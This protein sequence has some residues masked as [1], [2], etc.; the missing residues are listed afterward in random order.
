MISLD[1]IK[2]F[3]PANLHGREEFLLREYLQYKIL[4][5]IFQ[6]NYAQQFS[7]LGGTCL[8]IV[9]NNQRFSEDLDFDNFDLSEEDF[10]SVSEMIKS[11]LEA[12]GYTVQIRNVL[13]GAF[14]CYIRFPGLLHQ[15]GLSGHR[16]AKILINIVTEPQ[17]FTY[18]PD[19]HY[20]NKFDVFTSLFCT[21]P[22]ILLSQ[23]LYA[24]T[25]RRQPKGR[26]FFDAIFLMGW[27]KPNYQYLDY[28]LG[29]SSPIDLRKIILDKIQPFDFKFLAN[30]V[31]PFLFNPN[32]AMRVEQF[33]HYFKQAKL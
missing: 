6:S 29:V 11:G 13:R 24:I 17:G 4:E 32:D 3:Y 9:H 7:F 5:L 31:K 19:I 30:D 22:D 2:K 12:E 25:N 26:D 18:K 16:E 1:E 8:R 33:P 27:T 10:T 14:H 23:K 20:L 15:A 21:P 28:R